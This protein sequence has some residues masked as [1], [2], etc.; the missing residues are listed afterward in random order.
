MKKRSGNGRECFIEQR[1]FGNP[2]ILTIGKCIDLGEE[3][4][5]QEAFGTVAFDRI[6]YFFPCDKTDTFLQRIFAEE[7]DKSGGVPSGVGTAIDRIKLPRS[8]EAVEVF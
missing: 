6:A 7:K 5:T 2:D 4:G 8:A 3:M 1:G